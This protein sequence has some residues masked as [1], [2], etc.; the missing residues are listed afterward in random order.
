LAP[1]SGLSA[2]PVTKIRS[3]RR[4]RKKEVADIV[5][6]T[7]GRSVRSVAI[8]VLKLLEEDI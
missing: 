4:L 6:L 1:L 5:V 2:Q 8:E 7:D 3:R